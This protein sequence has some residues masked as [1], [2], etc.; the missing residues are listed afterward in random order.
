MGSD[1]AVVFGGKRLVAILDLP[2]VVVV[3]TPD[4]LLVV[5][6]KSSEKMKSVVEA[7]RAAGHADTL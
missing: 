1:R 3:D 6:R 4:A 5:A 2:D 7:V